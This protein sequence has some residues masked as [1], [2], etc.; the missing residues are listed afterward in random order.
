MEKEGHVQVMEQGQPE[1]E[2]PGDDAVPEA[3]VLRKSCWIKAGGH[4]LPMR[5]PSG[6]REEADRQGEGN[7][8][9]AG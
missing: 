8:Y 1:L 2:G 4:E 6:R 9:R 3:R 5:M 7:I